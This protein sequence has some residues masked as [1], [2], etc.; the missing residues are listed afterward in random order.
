MNN[1]SQIFI[2]SS[3]NSYF[4]TKSSKTIERKNAGLCSPWSDEGWVRNHFVCY[5]QLFLRIILLRFSDLKF[6]KIFFRTF[7]PYYFS[8]ITFVFEFYGI[9][10]FKI[11]PSHFTSVKITK[12]PLRSLLLRPIIH[13]IVL[14]IEFDSK[15]GA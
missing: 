5:D 1:D 2:L 14:S 15:K 13:C 4:R 7:A 8:L 11:R 12:I 10:Y 3:S 6:A 9:F